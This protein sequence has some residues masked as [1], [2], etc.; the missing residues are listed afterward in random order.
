MPGPLRQLYQGTANGQVVPLN[1]TVSV[2][3]LGSLGGPGMAA[4]GLIIT[5]GESSCK[6]WVNATFAVSVRD[7]LRLQGPFQLNKVLGMRHIYPNFERGALIR[8]VTKGAVDPP[9]KLVAAPAAPVRPA[10]A[11]APPS[12]QIIVKET[13]KEIVKIPCRYCSF[14]NLNTDSRCGSCGAP[15]R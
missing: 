12:P 8:N 1:V 7:E 10:V 11:S 4:R 15:T 9:A 14:L 6:L 3:G 13:I 2:S 5:D